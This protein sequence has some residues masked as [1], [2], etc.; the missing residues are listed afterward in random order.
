MRDNIG[1]QSDSVYMGSCHKKE[2]VTI[3]DQQA[4]VCMYVCMY[5]WVDIIE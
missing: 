3:E 5:V 4:G 1:N 2:G